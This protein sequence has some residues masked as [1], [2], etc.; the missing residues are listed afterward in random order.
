MEARIY[1]DGSCRGN[2]GPGGWGAVVLYGDG[3]EEYLSGPIP[4]TTNNRAELVA[5]LE[6]LKALQESSSVM[7]Y[8]DSRNV[9]GW[10]G[11]GWKRRDVYIALLCRQIEKYAEDHGH[12]VAYV[13]VEGHSADRLNE[14]ADALARDAVPLNEE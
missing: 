6:G 2:P 4:V 9:V 5:V 11:M 7:V 8:T 14:L 10:L 13:K 3:H 1:V 12:K